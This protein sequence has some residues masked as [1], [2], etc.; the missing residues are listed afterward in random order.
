MGD[1]RPLTQGI[2]SGD[3]ELRD[4]MASL[5]GGYQLSAAIGTVARLGVADALATGPLQPRD[6]AGRVGADPSSLERVLRA[7]DDAGLFKRLEDGRVALTALGGLLRS[8]AHA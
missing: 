3:A 8:D 5:I 1:G 7:L 4:R 6:L 2:Q